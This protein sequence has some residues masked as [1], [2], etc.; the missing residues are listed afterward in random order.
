MKK[1]FFYCVLVSVIFMGCGK[2]K[3]EKPKLI[4]V[5]YDIPFEMSP[6]DT[7]VLKDPFYA[8]GELKIFVGNLKDQRS[9]PESCSASTGGSLSFEVFYK[10]GQNT[11]SIGRLYEPGCSKIDSEFPIANPSSNLD[12]SHSIFHLYKVLPLSSR[13]VQ[14]TS[15]YTI[16][17]VMLRK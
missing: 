13:D 1:I 8:S 3:N 10:N 2:D 17:I 16:K 11:D 5:S 6:L 9:R 4:N 12:N 14:K 7:A 15:D